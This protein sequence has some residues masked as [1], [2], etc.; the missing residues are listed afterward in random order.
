MTAGWQ[1]EGSV[2]ANCYFYC[3]FHCLVLMY[4]LAVT[5]VKNPWMKLIHQPLPIELRSRLRFHQKKAGKLYRVCPGPLTC[6]GAY[7]PLHHHDLKL[8]VELVLLGC[9]WYYFTL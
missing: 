2:L 6:P 8:Q 3:V 7:T 4:I 9:N 1:S 5:S